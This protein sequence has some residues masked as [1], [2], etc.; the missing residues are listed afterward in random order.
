M[1]AGDPFLRSYDANI[2]DS[3]LILFRCLDS[4]DVSGN[5]PDT[6]AVPTTPFKGGIHSQIN[7][8]TYACSS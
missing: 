7:F 3:R 1:L 5:G 2:D 8:P 6:H 4:N